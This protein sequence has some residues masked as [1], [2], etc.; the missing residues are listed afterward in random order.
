MNDTT[1]SID[2]SEIRKSVF[3]TI[4]KNVHVICFLFKKA[5]CFFL[6]C[7]RMNTEKFPWKHMLCLSRNCKVYFWVE[8]LLVLIQERATN[9]SHNDITES[10]DRSEMRKS[11]FLTTIKNVCVICFLLKKKLI[12]FSLR[13]WQIDTENFL[14]KCM[15][16]LSFSLGWNVSR[17]NT[18]KSH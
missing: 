8:M 15:P 6:Q 14:W 2:K 4:I 13:C 3:L 9:T 1:E 12:L 5:D 10:I 17:I 18:R 7:W 11:I 16:C